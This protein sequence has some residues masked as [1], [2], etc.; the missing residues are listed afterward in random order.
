MTNYHLFIGILLVCLFMF[1]YA[2]HSVVCYLVLFHYA[3]YL[4]FLELPIFGDDYRIVMVAK[5]LL[6]IIV[7]YWSSF[8]VS[9]YKLL[10]AYSL[11]V[12]AQIQFNLLLTSGVITSY[13]F[14]IFGSFYTAIELVLFTF[15]CLSVVAKECKGAV[16]LFTTRFFGSGDRD[17]HTNINK[18]SLD[19]KGY[20]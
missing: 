17:L 11:L 16:N 20:K 5:D 15:G 13:Q 10:V 14:G 12:T 9:K 4:L 19:K 18:L 8:Y 3:I 1:K 7:I 6:L 2:K